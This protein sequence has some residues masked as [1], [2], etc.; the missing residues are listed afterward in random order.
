MQT[1]LCRKVPTEDGINLA[2][3]VYLPDGSG[4]FPVI[5]VRTPYHRVDQEGIAPTFVS[6]GYALVAQDCRGKYDSEGEFTPLIY[7]KVDGQAA[8]DWI[9]NQKWCNGRVGLWGRSYLGIV[10]VPAA[11]GGH[12]ALRCI[13][14]SVALSFETGCVM[15]VASPLPTPCAGR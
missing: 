3:D 1:D 8:V 7:E 15:T 11:S 14:P 5:L 10:Q 4:P 2:T 6:R 13:V 9:A 12:E